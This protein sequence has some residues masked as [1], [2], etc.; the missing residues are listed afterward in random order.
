MSNDPGT[1]KLTGACNFNWQ[2]L[3]RVNGAVLKTETEVV[4]EA[5]RRRGHIVN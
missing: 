3:S 4:S 1:C 2:V 5:G